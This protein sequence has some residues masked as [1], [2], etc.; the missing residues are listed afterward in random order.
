[1]SESSQQVNPNTVALFEGRRIRRVWH[2][3]RWFFSVID[4]IGALT[5]SAAPRKYWTAMKARI[6]DEGF[7]EV[8]TSC[9]QLKM[10]A[11]DGKMRYTDAA[12]QETLLRIIQSVPSPNAEPFKQWLARVGAERLDELENPGLAVERARELYKKQGYPEDWIERRIQGIIVR[13][14]LTDEWRERGAEEGREFAILTDILHRGT[15]G[16]K[17]E[18]HKAHKHLKQR[19]NLR[20]SMTPL[21]LA[22]TTLAEATATEIHQ[23]HYSEGFVELQTD[24]HDAGD[25]AGSARRDIEARTGRSVVSRDNHNTLTAR[26]AQPELPLPEEPEQ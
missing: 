19:D 6:Q 4:V 20:D 23:V 11:P 8:S 7:R 16:L 17:I 15:F 3:E 1:M 9:R 2:E 21:E 12:D 13:Q 26:A 25:V 14:G 10:L 24:V 22:L 18:G 5:D